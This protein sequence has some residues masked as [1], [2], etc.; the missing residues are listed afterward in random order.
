[1]AATPHVRDDYPTSADQMQ[2]ALAQVRAAAAE[3]IEL[4]PGAELAL[5]ELDRPTE[6]LARFGLGGNAGYLL[7]EAPYVGWPLD[8]L[9]QLFRLRS[10][11]ITPVLAHPERNPEVQRRPQLLEQVVAG[12]ALVQ[13]TA[14]SVTGGF[15][16]R[17]RACAEEL[18]QLE[19]A[20]LVASDA[21]GPAVDRASMSAAAEVL[22]DDDLAHWL[23]T[24]V[25]QA[26]VAD[27]PLPPRP[28]RRGR[29]WLGALSRR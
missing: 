16:W 27:A 8:L 23:T 10:S 24:A 13:L 21:H 15:G 2:S 1:L 25:P 3:T 5:A 19:L 18:L 22:K 20:H 12:G 4:L 17:A 7:V 6:D 26:I 29:S 28:P 11:G 9:D 14:G